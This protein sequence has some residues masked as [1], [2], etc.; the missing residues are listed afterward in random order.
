M[1][2]D[3]TKVL[4]KTNGRC[5]YCGIHLEKFQIDHIIPKA[6]NGSDDI[7]NLHAACGSCNILKNSY[8]ME[9]FRELVAGLV[10]SLNSYHNVYRIAKRY[11]LVSET[12]NKVIF[13]FEEL[14]NE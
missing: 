3:R 13:Y 1:K 9:I 14:N 7:D 12:G 4:T 5:A 8:T 2:I 6:I 11:N 10:K